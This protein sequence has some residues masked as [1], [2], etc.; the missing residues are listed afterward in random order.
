MI[1][2]LTSSE[3]MNYNKKVH[4]FIHNKKEKVMPNNDVINKLLAVE[5]KFTEIQSIVTMLNI[6]VKEKDYELI[7][8]MN[9]LNNKM[10]DLVNVFRK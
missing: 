1:K 9:I 8:I 2:N 6:W 5:D 10:D 7:P 4:R 3:P